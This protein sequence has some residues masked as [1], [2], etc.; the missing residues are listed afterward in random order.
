MFS[1]QKGITLVFRND[2]LEALKVSSTFDSISFVRDYLQKEIEGQ[3]RTLLM[4]QVPAIIHRLSLRLFVP[5]F[6]EKEDIE[7]AKESDNSVTEETITDPLASPPQ[8]PVDLNGNV[9]DPSQ[10]AS[11]SLDSSAEVHSLFSQKNLIR[12]ASLTDSNRTLSLFNP[13]MRDV[14]YRAWAGHME[15]GDGTGFQSPMGAALSRKHSQVTANTAHTYT[16]SSA[17][18]DVGSPAS[19]ATRPSLASHSSSFTG[20]TFGKHSKPGR[21]RKHRTINLRKPKTHTEDRE[22]V[23]EG[24][25]SATMSST[26][27]ENGYPAMVPEEREAELV[28]PP[29]SP[30]KAYARSRR[31]AEDISLQDSHEKLADTT[32]RPSRSEKQ[33][34]STRKPFQPLFEAGPSDADLTGAETFGRTLTD[35]T[36][37]IR[38]KPTR[39]FG[40]WQPPTDNGESISNSLQTRSTS[41]QKL[42]AP[43]PYSE[44]NP[45]GIL[46]QAWMMKMAG[47]IARRVTEQKASDAGFWD[48]GRDSTP[49]PAY[50]S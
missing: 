9:L 25:M 29:P 10:I 33:T 14:V 22:S 19:H 6:R 42:A 44:S 8:D 27:S 24:S 23:S 11:L 31:N 26:A 37:T 35:S 15:C 32:P 18:S 41:S 34:D 50:A 12:L 1:K 38:P 16:F 47:E 4:D 30:G 7:L 5:E 20:S 49:P 17:A 13:S 2:P 39:Y 45:G 40:S 28:T 36:A 48:D 21:K 46:E 43:F 3:L